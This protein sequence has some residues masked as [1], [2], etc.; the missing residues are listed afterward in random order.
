M[1]CVFTVDPVGL[2]GRGSAGAV[3][4]DGHLDVSTV[5]ADANMHGAARRMPHGV[6]E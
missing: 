2:A 5:A 3:V 1:T 4:V 6:G